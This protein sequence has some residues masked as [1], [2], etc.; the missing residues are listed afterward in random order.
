VAFLAFN[1]AVLLLLVTLAELVASVL[2]VAPS[3]DR[4]ERLLRVARS[5]YQRDRN[6]IEYDPRCARW[7]PL[8][9]YTLRPG[10]CVFSNHEFSN[11]FVVNR[12]GLRDDERALVAPDVVVLGD[13]H[14]MGWG[15]AQDATFAKRLEARTG[16][17]VLN[18]GIASYGTARELLTL[19][20]IDRS[21]LRLVVIQYC[22]N[23][24]EENEAFHKNGH[25]LPVM[26]EARYHDIADAQRSG[27]HYYFPRHVLQ[28]VKHSVVDLRWR[29]PR[30][31]DTPEAP[32]LFLGALARGPVELRGVP[33][34]VLEINGGYSGNDRFIPMLEA[35]L[36]AEPQRWR[37]LDLRPLDLAPLLGPEDY[38]RL[39]DHLNAR[40]NAV[41]ADALVDAVAVATR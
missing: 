12:L 30:G 25:E 39:D 41:V 11:R 19:S 20:R 14:A 37:R 9:G 27:A 40:G 32:K 1:V 3:L 21:R 2:L 6:E 24:F 33:V 31:A 17:T 8:V 35:I 23:D 18:A 15:V 7:D 34:V 22:N 13:S 5:V 26:S 38:Y 36:A 28:F 10:A 16:L 29:P 4:G